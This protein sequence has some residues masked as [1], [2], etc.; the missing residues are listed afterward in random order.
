MVSQ[1]LL[2]ANAVLWAW[3][4]VLTSAYWVGV[5]SVLNFPLGCVTLFLLV[6]ARRVGG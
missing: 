5:P 3:Y 2:L 1:V 4:A 6:R